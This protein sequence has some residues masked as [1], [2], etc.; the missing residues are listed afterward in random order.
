MIILAFDLATKTGVAVGGSY[1]DLRCWTEDLGEVG[2]AHGAR[3]FRMMNV[4]NTLIKKYRPKLVV[5]E[6]PIASGPAG[7]DARLGMAYGLRGVVCAMAYANGLQVREYDV[8]TVR[9]HYIGDGKL[10][11]AEA[12][13]A[14]FERSKLLGADPDGMDASDAVA[15]WDLAQVSEG[16]KQ[17]PMMGGL[18]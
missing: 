3:M 11:S 2:T 14:V 4:A 1:S 12:K 6:K 17:T 5:I 9:K 13:R 15:V 18:L 8:S 16:G 7:K 10:P